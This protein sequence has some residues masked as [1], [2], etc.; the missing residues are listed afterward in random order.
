MRSQFSY[1]RTNLR[2][3]DDDFVG[4]QIDQV[5]QAVYAGDIDKARAALDLSHDAGPHAWAERVRR[6]R[7]GVLVVEAA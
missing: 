7:R 2:A 6:A 5:M 3:Q 1:S 4:Q